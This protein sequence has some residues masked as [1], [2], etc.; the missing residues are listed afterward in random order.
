MELD[1]RSS[2]FKVGEGG[3]SHKIQGQLVQFHFLKSGR[4]NNQTLFVH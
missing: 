2:Y 1:K 4:T 3:K